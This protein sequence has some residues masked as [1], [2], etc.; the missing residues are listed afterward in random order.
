MRVHPQMILHRIFSNFLLNSMCIPTW[1]HEVYKNPSGRL[2]YSLVIIESP[3]RLSIPHRSSYI[4]HTKHRLA[5]QFHIVHHILFTP[6]TNTIC[7]IQYKLLQLR[8]RWR[9]QPDNACLITSTRPPTVKLVNADLSI[10][11][12]SNG[13]FGSSSYLN[14]QLD[15]YPHATRVPQGSL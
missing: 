7:T 3:P 9:R 5:C 1:V 13:T 8:P 12:V 11:N 15:I 4:V 2:I 14:C 10:L 6:N